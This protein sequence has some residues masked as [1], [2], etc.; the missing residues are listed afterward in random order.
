M[1]AFNPD[2]TFSLQTRI[3][4]LE[5]L[6]GLKPGLSDDTVEQDDQRGEKPHAQAQVGY[7]RY[8]T[9][10]GNCNRPAG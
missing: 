4:Y 10:F 5:E 6:A 8:N 3:Q 2:L 9:A 1:S 7:F